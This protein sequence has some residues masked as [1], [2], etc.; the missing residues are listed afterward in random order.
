MRITPIISTAVLSCTV[1][2]AAAAQTTVQTGNPNAAS[3]HVKTTWK[4][5]G[6]TVAIE[7]GRPYLKGRPESRMMPAGAVWRTGADE[8]TV[9]TTDKA[10]TFGK[11]KLEPG[12]YTINT[13]PGEKR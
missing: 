1:A 12:S 4:V 5:A 7:Y 6:A 3:P 8:A 11:I 13:E 9:I 2:F 10:L